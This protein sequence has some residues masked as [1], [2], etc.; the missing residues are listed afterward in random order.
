MVGDYRAWHAHGYC[1]RDYIPPG[2]NNH[3]VPVPNVT[4][5]HEIPLHDSNIRIH[6]RPHSH[7]TRDLSLKRDSV[8]LLP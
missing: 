3:S 1:F 8:H 6:L 7:G 2:S 4:H 5:A